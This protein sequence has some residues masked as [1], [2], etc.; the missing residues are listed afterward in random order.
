M[1]CLLARLLGERP[2]AG[3][4]RLTPPPSP[5]PRRMGGTNNTVSLVNKGR[6]ALRLAQPRQSLRARKVA[7]GLRATVVGPAS[8]TA[9]QVPHTVVVM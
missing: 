7:V 5:L 1:R 8:L 2:A 4:Q 9:S 6:P 3:P